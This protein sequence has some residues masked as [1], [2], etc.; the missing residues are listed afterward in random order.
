MSPEKPEIWEVMII[1]GGAAGL[2]AAL[3]ASRARI[4]T[5]LLEGEM[6][7][8]Q[9]ATADLVENYPG[10]PEGV[11]GPDLSDLM[12][13][14]AQRFGAHIERATVE[15]LEIGDGVF[16]AHA[17]QNEFRAR[18]V[19][20]ASGAQHKHLEVPGEEE[21]RG[22][23]VAY[24]ATCD[25]ALF[26]DR[27]IAVVGGGN[28]AM[29]DALLL[30]RYGTR[31][32]VIHRRDQLRAEKLLQERAFRHPK[33][34][35]IWDTVVMEIKGGDKVERLAL[36][37]VKSGEASELA[38]DGLFVAIGMEPRTAYLPPEVE[39]D[40]IGYVMVDARMRT[41]APG[42]FA[43]GDVI[44]GSLRQLTTAVGEATT[45][46]QSLQEY[47]ARVEEHAGGEI[48]R[49]QEMSSSR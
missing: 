49:G 14:Q 29:D 47:L 24:C 15:S 26:R 12:A 16:A 46:V 7:G 9:I 13:R 36:R 31:I 1:G 6:L 43:C 5:L 38:V 11:M 48:T 41:S 27:V 19:I 10:F 20:V 33:L 25:G 2:T 18:A 17:W 34:E 4:S 45:A 3:Y 23:G 44:R 37:N 21:F 22:R 8:G 40:G 28:V 30:S 42:I 39:R 35:F 32:Y